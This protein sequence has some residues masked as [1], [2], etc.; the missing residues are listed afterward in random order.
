MTSTHAVAILKRLFKA[1]RAGHAAR[2]IRSPP[3]GCRSRSARPPRRFPT[4]WTAASADRFTVAW[5][6]ERDTDDLE[7]RA[8]PSGELRPSDESIRA[9]LPKYI[10]V[11][12]QVPPQ[13][14]AIKIAGERAYDLARDGETVILQPR[15]VEVH[16]VSV[17]GTCTMAPS[18]FRGRVRQGH[19][20]SL[21][22]AIWAG[23]GSFG[24]ISA[25]RRTL[26]APFGE[27]GMVPLAQLEALCNR[28]ASGE[29]SLADALPLRPRWTTSR[30][31]PSHGLMRR[32]STGAEPVLLR[33]RDAPNS[34]GT[35]YVTVAIRVYG[36]A[37][38]LGAPSSLATA[39]QGG[40]GL[41]VAA[42]GERS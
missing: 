2:S 12:D 25:L 15:P 21:S 23:L 39:I 10:G 38:M 18:P 40:C 8:E 36:S 27:E 9:L 26:V 35:V 41:P 13:F 7:G 14:S 42:E 24:H 22:R 11:I 37:C 32:G 33:G 19:L 6:D 3:A 5:G 34:S 4:S 1:K 20:C 28:A 16:G 30:H 31:W 17:G 29:G